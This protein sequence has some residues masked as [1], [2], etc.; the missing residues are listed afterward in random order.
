MSISISIS[1]SMSISISI[2]I[3]ISTQKLFTAHYSG[4][5]MKKIDE[6]KACST[7]GGEDSCPSWF[8]WGNMRERDFE[9]LRL[10]WG[11]SIKMNLKEV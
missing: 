9:K 4:D 1:I 2:S 11:E 7:Y 8:W 6:D 5:K 10:R 3:D